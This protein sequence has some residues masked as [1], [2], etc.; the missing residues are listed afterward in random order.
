[1]LNGAAWLTIGASNEKQ[2]A[3]VAIRDCTVIALVW[4]A[5]PTGTPTR[6]DDADDQAVV[7]NAKGPSWPDSVGFSKPNTEPAIAMIV[8][9]ALGAEFEGQSLKTNPKSASDVRLY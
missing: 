4:E 6:T 2:S 5:Y 8:D 9:V 1:M 7:R 3:I